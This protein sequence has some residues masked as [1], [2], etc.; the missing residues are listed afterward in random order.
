MDAV[1]KAIILIFLFFAPFVVAD[2]PELTD[3]QILTQTYDDNNIDY[4]IMTR[5]NS[6]GTTTVYVIEVNA[7]AVVDYAS[8]FYSSGGTIGGDPFAPG[9]LLGDYIPFVGLSFN[10]PGCEA[11]PIC[12]GLTSST[13]GGT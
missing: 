6:D 7:L 12:F 9:M 5:L 13:N 11:N 3:I 4:V 8:T 2:G 1:R 10:D